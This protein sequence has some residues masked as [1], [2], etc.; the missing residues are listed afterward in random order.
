MERVE[1]AGYRGGEDAGQGSAALLLPTQSAVELGAAAEI[2]KAVAEA[3]MEEG[4][5]CAVWRVAV[6]QAACPNM[7]LGC[8]VT[9][10]AEQLQPRCMLGHV[11]CGRVACACCAVLAACLATCEPLAWLVCMWAGRAVH[12][13][14]P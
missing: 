5:C 6:S 11:A 14:G 4:A 9:T 8:T 10:G 3:A 7:H 2:S 13:G 1:G 12:Q